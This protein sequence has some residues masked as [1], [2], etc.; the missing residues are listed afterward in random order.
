MNNKPLALTKAE[1][2]EIAEFKVIKQMWGA[3]TQWE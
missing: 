3:E 2:R 1:I